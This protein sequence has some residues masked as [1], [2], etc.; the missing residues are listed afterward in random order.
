[1][2]LEALYAGFRPSFEATEVTAAAD[3]A[4]PANLPGCCLAHFQ[5]LGMI[6]ISKFLQ[7]PLRISRDLK[8]QKSRNW[9]S[10]PKNPT[11]NDKVIHPS[12][13]EGPNDD[14]YIGNVN[15]SMTMG[16]VFYPQNQVATLGSNDLYAGSQ[17][18]GTQQLLGSVFLLKIIILG[19]FG[20]H[21][22]LRKHLYGKWQAEQRLIRAPPS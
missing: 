21:H 14:S 22:Y 9:R 20:G 4:L 18:G 12:C 2:F 1:M 19:C 10:I 15:R 8:G 7:K 17:N 16:C 3:L 11:R 13:L 6:S 5:K